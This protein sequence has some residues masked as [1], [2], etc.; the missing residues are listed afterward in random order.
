MV[1]GGLVDGIDLDVCKFADGD[2]SEH[3]LGSGNVD[4]E[5]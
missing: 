2:A 1:Q 3:G 5:S 4:V